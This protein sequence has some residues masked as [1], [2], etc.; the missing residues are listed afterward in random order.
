MDIG[1]V[2]AYETV[3]LAPARDARDEAVEKIQG[4]TMGA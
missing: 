4:I 3:I 2:Q 1:R